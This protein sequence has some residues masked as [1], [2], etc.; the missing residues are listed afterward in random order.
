[1]AL[2][3]GGISLLI[4]HLARAFNSGAGRGRVAGCRAQNLGKAL[5]IRCGKT[6]PAQVGQGLRGDGD[7]SFGVAQLPCCA[8][9]V[10]GRFIRRWSPPNVRLA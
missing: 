8:A 3:P 5:W 7:F 4:N 9:I 6:L 1:M 2:S 10:A